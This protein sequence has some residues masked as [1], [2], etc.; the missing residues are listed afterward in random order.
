MRCDLG[1][2]VDR[3]CPAPRTPTDA[4]T[5][6]GFSS[7]FQ[8]PEPTAIQMTWT[9]L[10][11]D[12]VAQE[13]RHRE[14]GRETCELGAALNT[15]WGEALRLTR[16]GPRPV[17]FRAR[18][19]VTKG[20]E[21]GECSGGLSAR[22]SRP[23]ATFACARARDVRGS[24]P[25]ELPLAFM[26][27]VPVA[28]SRTPRGPV[29]PSQSRSLN[30]PAS[31]SVP[32]VAASASVGGWL[33]AISLFAISL[34]ASLAAVEPAEASGREAVAMPYACTVER[35]VVQIK[36]S[37]MRT[38]RVIGPRETQALRVCGGPNGEPCRIL[39]VYRFAFDCGGTRVAWIEAASA[40]SAGQ[41]W[42]LTSVGGQMILRTSVAS[43]RQ[44]LALPPGFAPAPRSGFLFAPIDPPRVRDA[45]ASAWPSERPLPRPPAAGRSDPPIGMAAAGPALGAAERLPAIPATHQAEPLPSDPNFVQT[46]DG[47]TSLLMGQGWTAT[48]TYGGDLADAGHWSKLSDNGLR[49]ALLAALAALILSATAVAAR[50]RFVPKMPILSALRVASA[51]ASVSSTATNPAADVP[52]PPPPQPRSRA[53]PAPPREAPPAPAEHRVESDHAETEPASPELAAWAAVAEMRTTAEALLDI[54][55]QM[56][57]DHVADAALRTVLE[58]D[59]AAISQRLEGPKLASALTDGRLDLVH[60]IYSQAIHDLERVRTLTRIEH[61][62]SLRPV[63]PAG[64][65]LVSVDD[66]CA[67][68][69]VNPRAGEAAAKKVVDALRQ[70]W[71]PDLARDEPDRLQREDRM[72]R[73]NAAWDMVRAR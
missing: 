58:A 62:R 71:H 29:A 48:V 7:L 51:P 13:L 47:A 73:I 57:G 3:S 65:A 28:S 46:T 22:T 50:Q 64:E 19:G 25:F 68:L 1:L 67:Y 41:P 35:G 2:G 36:R 18:R 11:F 15:R 38:Y 70:S 69:G 54:V 63:M 34:V 56:V 43:G 42:R 53:E 31:C 27:S 49:G 20:N 72:K 8:R 59:L 66:A 33:V 30:A 9:R 21:A 39:E 55:R 10:K 16:R 44:S 6:S 40:A 26:K 5:P 14:V 4:R 17:R 37:G 12:N 23:T 45:V 24:T 32:L 61:E 52:L 60:P